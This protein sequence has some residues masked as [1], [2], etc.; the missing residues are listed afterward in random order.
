MIVIKKSPTADTRTC[1]VKTVSK[2]ELLRSTAFH[3][4]DVRKGIN[5][6]A[7]MLGDRAFDHDHTKISYLDD[8][9]RDFQNNFVTTDWWK[10]HQQKER[11]H[12]D[13]PEGV[14]EDVNLIDVLEWIVDGVMAGK[15]RSGQYY[16]RKIPSALLQVAVK[17][18][19]ELLLSQVVVVPTEPTFKPGDIVRLI[20][21]GE[22]G[23]TNRKHCEQKCM[24]AT[25]MVVISWIIARQDQEYPERVGVV[26]VNKPNSEQSFLPRFALELVP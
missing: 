3:I 6:L 7:G 14:R 24:D 12:L 19:V 25:Y 13:S 22:I 11:H 26:D 8:F 17:N 16:Y 9:Y 20:N 5:Y 10:M 2:D 4:N 18:T 21:H 23:V 15:A 1:D